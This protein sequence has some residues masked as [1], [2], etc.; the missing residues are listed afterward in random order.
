MK[1]QSLLLYAILGE[2]DI[3]SQKSVTEAV[4]EAIDGGA[5]IIQLREKHLQGKEL[6]ERARE[7]YR[8]CKEKDVIFLLNDDVELAK[9]IDCHGVH[10]GQNDMPPEEAKKILG[11]DKIV[12]VSV[13]T[14]EEAV[15]AEKNGA[16]Y[17]GVGAVFPTGSKDD[18]LSVSKDTIKQI[19]ESVSIPVV[20]IGGINADNMDKLQNMGLSGICVISAIFAKENITLATKELK[21][22]A[23]K[24]FG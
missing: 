11:E 10:V 21:E 2:S 5:G 18:A 3:K 16:D 8:L 14:V 4:K 7:V 19:C 24:F 13:S 9:K 12:G 6:E 23:V 1:K 20:A 17:L 22:K 15:K